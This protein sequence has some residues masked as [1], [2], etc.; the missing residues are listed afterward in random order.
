MGAE[1]VFDLVT[2]HWDPFL[3]LDLIVEEVPSLTMFGVT[4][5]HIV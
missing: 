1:V 5:L 4:F 2:C 3:L